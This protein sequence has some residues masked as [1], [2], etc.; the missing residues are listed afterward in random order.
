MQCHR[1]TQSS[2]ASFR[3]VLALLESCPV[4]AGKILKVAQSPIYARGVPMRTLEQALVTLGTTTLSH[5][6]L[7]VALTRVFRVKAFDHAMESLRLHSIAVAHAT[8]LICRYTSFSD[9]TGFLCGLLHDIGYAMC[10]IVLGDKSRTHAPVRFDEV[11]RS[12]EDAHVE[13]GEILCDLWKLPPDVKMVIAHHHHPRIQGH[14]HPLAA[15]IVIAEDLADAAGFGSPGESVH[16][17]DEAQKALGI[18]PHV[19][20]NIAREF[21]AIA[22]KLH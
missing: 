4:T 17:V 15:A 12:V 5:I 21:T 8:R 13:A 14:I 2:D 10:L 7:E 19:H 11:Q 9:E 18:A 3:E 6:F 16:H 22:R 1:L 20:N